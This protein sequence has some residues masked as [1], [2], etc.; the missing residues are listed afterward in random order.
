VTD[1]EKMSGYDAIVAYKTDRLSRGTQEDFTRIEYWATSNGKRLI[2]VDGPQYPA[3]S[4]RHEADYW[5]WHAE[6]EAARKEWENDRERVLRA[7]DKLRRENKLVGRVPWGFAI[8]GPKYD[9]RL[10]ATGLGREYI[11][12]ITERQGVGETFNAG[13]GPAFSLSVWAEFGPMLQ[14]LT[15]RPV[16]V[17]FAERRI[18][19]QDVYI[20]NYQKLSSAIGWKPRL[21]PR[22]GTGDLVEWMADQLGN[23]R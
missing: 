17:S 4:D 15:G 19:D 8:E 11:P 5:Q 20:S 12:M 22:D 23:Q 3:R 18:G 1:P 2:I 9:K 14:E 6:K 16:N 13:G 21:S 10:V 7:T